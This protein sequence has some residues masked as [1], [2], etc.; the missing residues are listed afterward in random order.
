MRHAGPRGSR[1]IHQVE[2]DL[3]LIR[4]LRADIFC[5]PSAVLPTEKPMPTLD[6]AIKSDPT[7]RWP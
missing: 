2:A 5:A 4:L 6:E 3:F 1:A 7:S